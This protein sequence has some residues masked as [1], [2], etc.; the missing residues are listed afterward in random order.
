MA[1]KQSLTP[2]A[3]TVSPPSL[4]LPS[5]I[6]FSGLDS[7]A[8]GVLIATCTATGRLYVVDPDLC[9]LELLAGDVCKGA[10]RD[11]LSQPPRDFH[12]SGVCASF[13]QPFAVTIIDSEECCYVADGHAIRRITLPAHYFL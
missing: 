2:L 9:S 4:V 10:M 1:V 13:T 8:S 5:I 7:T 6:S 11:G 3:L 12:W